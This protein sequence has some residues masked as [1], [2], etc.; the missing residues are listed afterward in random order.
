MTIEPQPKFNSEVGNPVSG[1]SNLDCD[2][3]QRGFTPW[4]SLV[5][6]PH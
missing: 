4:K 1:L 5:V 3:V 6:L 2:L